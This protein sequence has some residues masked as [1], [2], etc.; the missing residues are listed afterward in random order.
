MS[1]RTIYFV[2]PIGMPGPIKIGSTGNLT[3]RFASLVGASPIDLELLVTIPGSYELEANIHDCLG[4]AHIR[5]EW[6]APEP[7]ILALIDALKAGVPIHVALDLSARERDFK[8][9]LY[10]RRGASRRA[11]N[12][13]AKA[14]RQSEAA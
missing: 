13:A 6:F 10:A 12:A 4:R 11:S 5:H 9:E 8:A 7:R 1:E 2:K 3:D 14:K